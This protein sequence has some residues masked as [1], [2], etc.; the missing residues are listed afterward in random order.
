MQGSTET[1]AVK[2][3]DGTTAHF[4]ISRADA[5]DTGY[6]DV[7]FSELTFSG[8]LNA[9]EGLASTLGNTLKKVKPHSASVELGVELA[10]KE[11]KLLA[12]FVQGEGKAN[13]KITLEWGEG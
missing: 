9:I 5:T 1:R 7:A 8:V 4:E 3:P 11:G 10:A 12:V 13:L 6:S 2:L